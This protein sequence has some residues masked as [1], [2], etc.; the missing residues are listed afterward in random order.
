MLGNS[1]TTPARGVHSPSSPDY[2]LLRNALQYVTILCST[3]PSDLY[4]PDD[5]VAGQENDGTFLCVGSSFA[6]A[7]T[8]KVFWHGV[9]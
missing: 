5:T 4:R 3:D 8:R 1:T 9:R 7:G 6:G 2:P